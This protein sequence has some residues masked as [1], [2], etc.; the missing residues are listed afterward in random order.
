M[1]EPMA[2][3]KQEEQQQQQELELEVEQQ[4]AEAQDADTMAHNEE[5]EMP[6]PDSDSHNASQPESLVAIENFG[7]ALDDE[8]AA[9]QSAQQYRER[10]ELESSDDEDEHATPVEMSDTFNDEWATLDEDAAT[11]AA[12]DPDND[13]N[14]HIDIYE[15]LA[16][17]DL[18]NDIAVN[19][20]A[21]ANPNYPYNPDAEL[22][23][24]PAAGR[25]MPKFEKLSLLPPT[26]T[27]LMK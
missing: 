5:T 18:S 21:A 24:L 9:P 27:T 6:L 17:V 11:F 15:N 14:N 22:I 25:A 4:L 12:A 13:L 26:P 23:D 10:E 2:E 8:L 16:P 19:D 7:D 20:I 1:A 3:L